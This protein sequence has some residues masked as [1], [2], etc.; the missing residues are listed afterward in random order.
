MVIFLAG[1]AFIPVLL[2]IF[3][4]FEGNVRYIGT[5]SSKGF[6]VFIPF[7]SSPYANS[8]VIRVYVMT[9]DQITIVIRDDNHEIC[10][11][12][13]KRGFLFRDQEEASPQFWQFIYIYWEWPYVLSHVCFE[14]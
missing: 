3:P 1:I 14:K 4:N 5:C 2:K 8:Y 10:T 9:H 12:L 13:Q 11:L 6:V 7:C